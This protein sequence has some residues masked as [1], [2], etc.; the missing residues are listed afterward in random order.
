M[1]I[2]L[3][4]Y[5]HLSDQELLAVV[6]RLVDDERHA[7]AALIRSLMELDAR[8]LYLQEGFPSMFVYCTHALRLSEH[9]AY[10]RIEVARAAAG[11]RSCSMR[12]RTATS[13]SRPRD[14]LVRI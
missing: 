5:S 2:S 7:T 9:A 10:N 13:R 14:C 1:P 6:K 11:I 3:T 12:S 4:P 8:R